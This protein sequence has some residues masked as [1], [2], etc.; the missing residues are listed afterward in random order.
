MSC[1]FK[2]SGYRLEVSQCQL[3]PHYNQDFA[4]IF[5]EGRINFQRFPPKTFDHCFKQSC[6]PSSSSSQGAGADLPL[7]GRPPP[8]PF[9][10]VSS[11]PFSS[12]EAALISVIS[13]PRNHRLKRT[14]APPGNPSLAFFCPTGRPLVTPPT[15]NL[16]VRSVLTS[17][18]CWRLITPPQQQF[19]H[20]LDRCWRVQFAGRKEAL[21]LS[22]EPFSAHVGNF[23]YSPSQDT[24]L[25]PFKTSPSISRSQG[26]P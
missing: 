26:K 23:P 22:L 8:C 12:S 4:N 7:T 16:C 10:G 21:S 11:P 24:P 9:L 1:P 14:R 19:V 20:L 6:S 18:Q 5:H 15:N 25:L 2:P 13:N 17:V 3:Y